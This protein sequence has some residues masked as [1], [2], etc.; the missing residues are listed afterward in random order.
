MGTVKARLVDILG[1]VDD[2][3]GGGGEGIAEER[4]CGEKG[5]G[6]V[7]EEVELGEEGHGECG[8]G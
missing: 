4:G 7:G 3:V 1:K 8:D 6:M 5:R 2:I